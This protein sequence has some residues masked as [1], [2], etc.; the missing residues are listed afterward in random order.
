MADARSVTVRG[1][2]RQGVGV[3]LR[4]MTDL[5]GGLVVADG[6]VTSEWEEHRLVGVRHTGRLIRGVGAFELEPTAWGTRL[7]WW[8]EVDP[9]FGGL[10]EAVTSLAIVPRVQRLFRSSLANL[11]RLCEQP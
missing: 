3:A 6:M 9:P 2:Q 7:D 5:A 11:K 4:C 8:E 1:P 10:G